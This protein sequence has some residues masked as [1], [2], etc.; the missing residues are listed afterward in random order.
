MNQGRGKE[1]RQYGT[2]CHRVKNNDCLSFTPSDAITETREM[3]A[4]LV[5]AIV[6]DA[7]GHTAFIDEC[8]DA[9]RGRSFAQRLDDYFLT[10]RNAF[11]GLVVRFI[12]RERFRRARPVERRLRG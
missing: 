8:Q 1:Y 12:D 4:D 11:G 9:G 7:N 10:D 2:D 5:Y 3:H 6:G